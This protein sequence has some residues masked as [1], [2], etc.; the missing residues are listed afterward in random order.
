MPD[1]RHC[2]HMGMPWAD[3]AFVKEQ[4]PM[5][6]YRLILADDGHGVSRRIELEARSAKE[7][8]SLISRDVANRSV[9]LQ[10]NGKLLATIIRIRNASWAMFREA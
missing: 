8:L 6:T 10:E 9:E 1:F 4:K 2:V 5:R 3:L 7:A